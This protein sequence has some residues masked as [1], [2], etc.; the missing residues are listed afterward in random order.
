MNWARMGQPWNKF[1]TFK[2]WTHCRLA[3]GKWT[4][5]AR[6]LVRSQRQTHYYSRALSSQ[7]GGRPGHGHLF[8]EQGSMC[9]SWSFC[10]NTC[11]NRK[12]LSLLV[13]RAVARLNLC[14]LDWVALGS[15]SIRRL[16][17]LLSLLELR[18]FLSSEVPP[19]GCLRSWAQG[20]FRK[21]GS[22]FPVTPR[23]GYF[24]C[25]PVLPSSS[26]AVFTR[27]SSPPVSAPHILREERG[28]GGFCVCH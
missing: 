2:Y 23:T 12:Y 24:C 22:A 17:K 7:A 20:S 6:W 16:M 25:C 10:G 19:L 14:S 11:C 8:G 21:A 26:C 4:G 9:G 1:H 13:W 27:P 15:H 5:A 28:M 18:F 3:S